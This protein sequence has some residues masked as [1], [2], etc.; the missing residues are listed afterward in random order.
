M[1][2]IYVIILLTL[3]YMEGMP[4]IR[5]KKWAE[6]AVFTVLMI[7]GTSII[8]M[9]TVAFEPYRFSMVI[10]I[11]FRPYTNAVKNFITGF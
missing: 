10:D 1:V 6:L 9:N 4:L 8:V 11:I 7:A 3:A 5:K 2:Y